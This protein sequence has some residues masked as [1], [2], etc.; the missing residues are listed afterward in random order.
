MAH[1]D[2]EN[3]FPN[4]PHDAPDAYNEALK[5]KWLG[6]LEM[7]PSWLDALIENLDEAQLKTPMRPG[8]W[9][10]HQV[11]HH[12]SDTHMVAY[13]RCKLML[14]EEIPIIKPYDH[15]AWNELP[16]VSGTPVNIAI[17]LLHALHRRWLAL[18]RGLSAAA[19]DRTFFHP[20]KN[21]EVA[22]WQ[23]V[24]YYAWHGRHHMEQMR[25]FRLRQGWA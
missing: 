16:D 19:W 7:L 10:I 24:A 23:H 9:S 14:T 8:G 12:L 11:M 1:T 6:A 20:E 5:A 15:D 4:G 17:T 18:L 22:L 25:A 21:E 3:R 2:A 13:E